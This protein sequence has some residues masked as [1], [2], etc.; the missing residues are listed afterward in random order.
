LNIQ[1]FY[2][3]STK[4]NSAVRISEKTPIFATQ[5]RVAFI[6]E[7]QCVYHAIRVETLKIIILI[8]MSQ[9]ASHLPLA[10]G[11]PISLPDEFMSVVWPTG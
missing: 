1:E 7:R 9:A 11:G 3:L 2:I 5:L 8:V 6:T 10:A 4:C